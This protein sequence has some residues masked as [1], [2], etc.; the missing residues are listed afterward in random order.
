LEDF[1]DEGCLL[2][3]QLGGVDWKLFAWG[4]ILLL[5]YFLEGNGLQLGCEVIVLMQ[6]LNILGKLVSSHDYDGHQAP[7]QI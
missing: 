5:A 7:K 6:V 4:S 3:I 2:V 1:D